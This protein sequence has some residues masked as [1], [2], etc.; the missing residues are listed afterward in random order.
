MEG[1]RDE[2]PYFQMCKIPSG[3]YISESYILYKTIIQTIIHFY[4]L[5]I[6]INIC[7]CVSVWVWV[8]EW[9]MHEK[10][11]IEH[12][13][14]MWTFPNDIATYN[15]IKYMYVHVHDVAI[16]SIVS[17]INIYVYCISDLNVF[18]RAYTVQF[19]YICQWKGHKN[20]DLKTWYV[21]F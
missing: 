17:A 21:H 4:I 6:N 16:L 10:Y 5:Y 20:Y 18:A 2:A 1:R 15:I 19:I 11:K 14:L 8:F 13:I 3:L 12:V 7:E 9:N